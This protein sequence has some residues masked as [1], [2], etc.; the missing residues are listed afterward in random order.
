MNLHLPTEL[1]LP[2]GANLKLPW[3]QRTIVQC[4]LKINVSKTSGGGKSVSKSGERRVCFYCLD[5][6]HMI[7]DC[8]A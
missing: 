1:S 7:Y 3:L 6:G 4:A 2:L 5:P 8:K